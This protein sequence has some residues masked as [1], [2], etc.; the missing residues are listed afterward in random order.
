MIT[1]TCDLH[2]VPGD[3]DV[4]RSERSKPLKRCFRQLDAV[5]HAGSA[6][7]S[8][9]DLQRLSLVFKITPPLVSAVL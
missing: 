7:V 3:L 2:K 4:L 1:A 9:I 5:S 6:L 8:H